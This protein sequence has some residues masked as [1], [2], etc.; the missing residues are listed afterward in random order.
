FN[1]PGY[2][3]SREDTLQGNALNN[4]DDPMGI[5]R[6][7]R[8]DLDWSRIHGPGHDPNDTRATVD[9]QSSAVFGRTGAC[10]VL[11]AW[12]P[13]CASTPTM[14]QFDTYNLDRR[15]TVGLSLAS[16]FADGSL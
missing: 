9:Q 8:T 1:R 2:I 5:C 11:P 7:C 6:C 10:M 13:K 15:G 4:T 14:N 16:N 3:Y 12:K